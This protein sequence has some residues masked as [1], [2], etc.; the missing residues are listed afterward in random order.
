[1]SQGESS[2]ALGSLQTLL[3]S[4]PDSLRH[5]PE[6]FRSPWG[7]FRYS[8]WLICHKKSDSLTYSQWVWFQSLSLS[9][10]YQWMIPSDNFERIYQF[11][12]ELMQRESSFHHSLVE[13]WPHFV[14]VWPCRSEW[15]I[16]TLRVSEV[17]DCHLFVTLICWAELLVSLWFFTTSDFHS[18]LFSSHKFNEFW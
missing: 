15:E 5:S 14:P 17:R 6:V 9:L 16:F 11:L 12:W 18:T 13:N 1:M 3:S 8:P 2:D 4:L 7:V 10:G